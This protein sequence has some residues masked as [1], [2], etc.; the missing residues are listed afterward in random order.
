MSHAAAGRILVVDD[1]AKNVEVISRLM[2]R[3]GYDVLT[4]T[5][6]ELALESVARHKPD[7][8]APRRQHDRDRRL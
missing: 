4:A 7:S 5:S 1:E 3:L 8:R 2:R 6:G